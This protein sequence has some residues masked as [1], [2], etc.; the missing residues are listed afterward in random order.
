MT[1]ALFADLVELGADLGILNTDDVNDCAYGEMVGKRGLGSLE[2]S[3]DE[4]RLFTINLHLNQ[5]S[6]HIHPYLL[7]L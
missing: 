4:S 2:I 5:L 1:T 6:M 3:S 7:E